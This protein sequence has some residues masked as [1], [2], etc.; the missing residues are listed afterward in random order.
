[1]CLLINYM[2][3]P[4]YFEDLQM[5]G[6][7]LLLGVTLS[8]VW[9]SGWTPL[10][11]QKTDFP[12]LSFEWRNIISSFDSWNGELII[13]AGFQTTNLYTPEFRLLVYKY[14][15]H[16]DYNQI[17]V[18]GRIYRFYNHIGYLQLTDYDINEK[19]DVYDADDLDEL[20]EE[21]LEI[22]NGYYGT[23]SWIGNASLDIEGRHYGFIINPEDL[24]T[25][26]SQNV[27][28][29]K[30][31]EFTGNAIPYNIYPKGFYEF[32]GEDTER[33]K[34]LKAVLMLHNLTLISDPNGTIRM[35]NKNDS[36]NIIV[37]IDST[38]VVEFKVKRLNRSIPDVSTL[39]ILI[40]DTTMLKS[41]ISEYYIAFFSQ[42]WE[43]SVTIDNLLK[44]QLSLFDQIQING[45]TYR[46][47]EI[48]RDAKADEYKIKAW[49]L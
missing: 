28:E 18:Y 26:G 8:H 37:A 46:I 21:R 2:Y 19:T 11:I 38:D 23:T 35:V 6:V 24:P 10:N 25:N 34:V 44:Y 17:R 41:I 22:C 30:Y 9:G 48:Q 36:S 32:G 40:G 45:I 27:T 16:D 29:T 14:H 33:L 39:D 15:H 1:M 7:E 12:I 13:E 47:T 42:I 4:K 20:E 5:Q 49:E 3:S 31:L 43:L